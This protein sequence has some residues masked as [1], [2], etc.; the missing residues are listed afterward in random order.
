MEVVTEKAMILPEDKES[1]IFHYSFAIFR[2][3]IVICNLK[4]TKIIMWI[5]NQSYDQHKMVL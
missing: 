4:N 2:I 1:F 3:Y 5:E